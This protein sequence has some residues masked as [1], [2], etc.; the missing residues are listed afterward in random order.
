MDSGLPVGLDDL[1]HARSVE[2]NRREFKAAWN[3]ATQAAVVRT[4]CAFANDLLNL[5][6]GY[7]ILGVETDGRGN[8]SSRRADWTTPTGTGGREQS[9]V[10]AVESIRTIIPSSSRCR[11]RIARCW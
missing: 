9:S 11:I 7:V 4:I 6:G 5:N 8:P 1:I 3:A 10:N 2:D